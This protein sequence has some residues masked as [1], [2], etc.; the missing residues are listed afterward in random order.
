MV[1]I[2]SGKSH[3]FSYHS[4]TVKKN[5]KCETSNVKQKN[6]VDWVSTRWRN[7]I[8]RQKCSFKEKLAKNQQTLQLYIRKLFQSACI[9]FSL[10]IIHIITKNNNTQTRYSSLKKQN[11]LQAIF[12]FFSYLRVK[13][14]KTLPKYSK[15]L[16]KSPI[17]N[18]NTYMLVWMW[19]LFILRYHSWTKK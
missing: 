12:S 18:W 3:V 5:L 6:C 14:A 10:F 13:Y 15:N 16:V 17:W 9:H 1:T 2:K 19:G 8:Q 4:I 11:C 7:I